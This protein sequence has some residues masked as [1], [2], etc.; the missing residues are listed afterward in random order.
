MIKI[1]L[2]GSTGSIG[3][4][5]LS[6]V[7][8]HSD[9][10]KIVSLSAN[11]SYEIFS[12]QVNE[13]KP[14]VACLTDPV[15]AIKITEIPS[16]TT[17]YTGENAT[18]HAITE[19]CDIV[20]VAISGFAGLAPVLHAIEMGK[21]VALANKETLVAG[22][23]IVMKAVREKGVRL[24]PVDSEHSAIFQCLNFNLNAEFKKLILTASGGAFRN[25]SK[26]EIQ[27]LKASE[28]LKHPNWLMGKKITID[29]A[30]LLNKGLEVIEACHLYSAP[31]SKVEAII[32]PESIIH[33]MVEF[34]D[35]AIMA[36]LGYPSMEI[37]I[38][39]ALTYPNRLKTDVSFL[40]LTQK[41]LTFGK[42]DLDK[43]P[44]FALALKS[45]EMGDNYACAMN[46]A[47]E[48]AV[49]LYLQDKIGFYDIADLIEHALVNIERIKVSKESLLYTDGLARRLV[50]E[51]IGVKS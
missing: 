42:I 30:T 10:F 46:A 44:C 22:G 2:L 7:A 16:E 47:N 36:Q 25:F 20:F 33:S 41:S 50:R 31:L 35:G 45:Y 1:A 5:V 18:L 39:L 21:D 9:K 38:Q 8:R 28:A 32:H 15:S 3:R 23:E 11:S 43:Y 24:I 14:Q 29:C 4:Q 34:E 26:I 37:P 12:K 17:L 51:K 19:D 49:G 13:F 6:T 27:N 40:D 48:V